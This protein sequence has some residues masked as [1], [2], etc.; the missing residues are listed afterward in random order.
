MFLVLFQL[1]LSTQ[2][3]TPEHHCCTSVSRIISN[4]FFFIS[5]APFFTRDPEDGWVVRYGRPTTLT[6]GTDVQDAQISFECNGEII[7]AGEVTESYE[8]GLKLASL[9]K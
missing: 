1:F 4:L 3:H 6:C 9:G 7:D 5:T 2:T 8:D